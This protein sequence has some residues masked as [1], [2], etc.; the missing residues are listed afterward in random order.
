VAREDRLQLLAS[1]G[2]DER[3]LVL[4]HCHRTRYRAGTVIYHAGQLGDSLYVITRGRVAV[5]A[6][7]TLGEPLT[8]AIMGVGDA[9][10]EMAL[11]DPGHVRTATITAIEPVEALVLHQRDFDELRQ[12]GSAVNELLVQ[13]LVARVRRLTDQVTELAELTA[14]TRIYRR[15]LALGELFDVVDS[16]GSLPVSQNQLASMAGVGLRITNRVLSEAKAAGVLDTGRRRVLVLDWP[17]VRRRAG[18][19]TESDR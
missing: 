18:L 15:L 1:L 4:P 6:G 11:I 5:S 9:F 16:P 13:V 7:G 14:P 17:A 3:R 8:L 10:G 19:R 12:E 2:E